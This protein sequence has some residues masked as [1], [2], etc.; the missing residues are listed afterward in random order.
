LVALV[1]N[2]A[3]W[4][5][6]LTAASARD[7]AG[8]PRDKRKEARERRDVLVVLGHADATKP[9]TDLAAATRDG[10]FS[11]PLVLVEGTLEFGFDETSALKVTLALTSQIAGGDKKVK[12]L[13]DRIGE[14]LR[15]PLADHGVAGAPALTAKLRDAFAQGAREVPPAWLDHNAERLLLEQR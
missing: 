13:C 8:V 4:K 3:A 12:E 14:V 7:D 2:H 9:A 5:S 10:T 1:R 6:L 15:G 11:P